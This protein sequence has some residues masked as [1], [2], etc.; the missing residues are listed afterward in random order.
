[1]V[2]EILPYFSIP[3]SQL[4]AVN[5]VGCKIDMKLTY[6]FLHSLESKISN[7][8]SIISLVIHLRIY[9]K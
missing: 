5:F 6:N 3:H 9:E 1:M 8:V 4:G 7:F 2:F